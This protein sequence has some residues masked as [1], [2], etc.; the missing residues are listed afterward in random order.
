MMAPRPEILRW[1]TA[2]ALCGAVFMVSLDATVVVAAFVSWREHFPQQSPEA[3]GW[4]INIYTL[5]YAALLIPAGRWSDQTG[6]RRAFLV[7]LA[8]FTLSSLACAVTP[9]VITLV[10]ARG[11]QAIGAAMI[12]PSA[13]ALLLGAASPGDRAR[14]VGMWAA[15]GAL[16]AAIGPG[17]GGWLAETFTWRAIFWI[18]VP[19]GIWVAA[20]ISRSVS[21]Q[22]EPRASVPPDWIG[23]G[24]LASG[25]AAVLFGA[26]AVAEADVLLREAALMIA[27]GLGLLGACVRWSVRRPHPTLDIALLRHRNVRFATAATFVFGAAFSLMFLTFFAF[28][29]S[30]WDYS[31]AR[32]GAVAM[33]GPL[34]VI[35][36]AILAGRWTGSTGQRALL[37]I[38]GVLYAASQT[39][40]AL[41]LT[42]VP[43][44]TGVML[45]AQIASG[46]A[47]GLLLPGL[48]SAAIAELPRHSLAVGSAMNTAVRQLGSVVGVA[49]GVTTIGGVRPAM[50]TFQFAYH[51]LAAGGLVTAGLA[52]AMTPHPRVEAPAAHG[53]AGRRSRRDLG[54]SCSPGR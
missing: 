19:V 47:I 44:Y 26:N 24:L 25:V 18:N 39:W 20:Q 30:V 15:V 12:S 11:A 16:A 33:V 3:L 54:R 43:D 46:V 4:V 10:I 37:V 7:G 32:A 28:T 41:R 9:T 2:A 40:S 49:I 31:Q 45:P 13:L 23:S 38:G 27:L 17:V 36:V 21:A 1:Q 14:L 5:I 42:T 48:A 51:L 35:P 53:A 50:E 34:V 6:H 22:V 52:W 29:T 8:V